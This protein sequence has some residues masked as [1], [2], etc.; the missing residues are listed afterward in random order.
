MENVYEY[1]ASGKEMFSDLTAKEVD[2]NDLD[3]SG[4]IFTFTELPS[5]LSN[6]F[7]RAISLEEFED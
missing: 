4:S 5:L 1:E 2:S 7:I 3:I 6:L